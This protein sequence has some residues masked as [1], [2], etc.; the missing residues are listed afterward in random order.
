MSTAVAA[1]L[2]GLVAVLGVSL[3]AW[4]L[5]QGSDETTPAD[6]PA[7]ERRRVLEEEIERS[8]AAL[9]E[10]EFDRRAGNLSAE[11]FAALNAQERARAADL[12]RQRDEFIASS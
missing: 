10:I 5:L 2:V 9:R 7:V 8:L 11:D 4:P 6:D 12:L 1:L 3:V